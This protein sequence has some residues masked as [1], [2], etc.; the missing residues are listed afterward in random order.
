MNKN[1]VV[2]ARIFSSDIDARMAQSL[3]ED[4]GIKCVLDNETFSRIYPIGF[5]SIGGIRLMVFESDLERAEKILTEA[6]L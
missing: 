1:D 4:A 3:L 5:N 2:L 6:K